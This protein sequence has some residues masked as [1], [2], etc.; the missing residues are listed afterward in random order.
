[1][2]SEEGGVFQHTKQ[3]VDPDNIKIVILTNQKTASASEFLAGA[4]QDSDKAVIVGSDA[5]TL[6]KVSGSIFR[7]FISVSIIFLFGDQSTVLFFRVFCL[8]V[9]C[10][11]PFLLLLTLVTNPGHWPARDWATERRSVK[12]DVS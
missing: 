9:N 5:S 1:M 2:P 4:F 7:A 11:S 8:G 12:A 10:R 3:L 6:G